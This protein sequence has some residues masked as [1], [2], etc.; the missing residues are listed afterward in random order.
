MR[1]TPAFDREK[2]QFRLLLR[3]SFG[4]LMDTAVASRD[5]DAAQFVIWS[6]ALLASPAF[7]FAAKMMG[8]YVFLWRRPDVLLRVVPE[9]RL[10]F[11]V[12]MMLATGL[13]AA[14]LWEALFPDRQ[15][16]EIVGVL[17]VRPR[18]VALARL[19]AAMVVATIFS[20]AIAAPS[21]FMY[22]LNVA[23][24]HKSFHIVGWWPPVL[25]A[26]VVAVTSAG[27][28]TFAALLAARGL[29]VLCLGGATVQRAAALLQLVSVVLLVESFIFLPGVLSGLTSNP[30]I[31]AHAHLLPPLWFLALYAE[32]SGASGVHAG[33]LALAAIAATAVAVLIAALVYMLPARWNARRVI[34]ARVT[35]R[36][37]RSIARAERIASPLLR[38]PA[39]RA[40]F[41]FVLSSLARSR[42]HALIVATY[43]GVGIS[44]AGIWLMRT[45]LRGESLALNVPAD[46]LISIP[47]VLT[48]FLVF[49]LRSAFKVPTDLDANWTFRA[50]QPRSMAPVVDG[51]ALA[52]VAV[53][54]APVTLAW[55]VVTAS[56]WDLRSALATSAM[57]A[58]SGLAL[59]EIVLMR[60]EAVPFTR[61]HA[62]ATSGVRA[63]W[64]VMFAALHF[65]AFKLEDLQLA[66]LGSTNGILLYVGVMLGVAAAARL[67]R[68]STQAT[69]LLEFDA[70][71]E[72]VTQTLNLSRATG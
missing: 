42:R 25:I 46:D 55:F 34:E 21:G 22:S 35:N 26:H 10:F 13:L 14:V 33:S 37:S 53:A 6:F 44:V 29:A 49:G 56:F 60:C 17:P 2:R 72:T 16:Q 8:K 3:V 58:A 19:A 31:A 28:F 23:V 71:V 30:T 36:A 63:G 48:F 38:S 51:V 66:A 41:V 62:P 54:V 18:T 52:M 45:A 32:L 64:A 7:F 20:A 67:R 9:D 57:H 24:A 1:D 50:A 43:L 12:Y 15:D 4:R 27:M 65:Y 59:V 70:P 5:V 39:A 11:I 69:Q 47:L 40:V 68:R 61:A